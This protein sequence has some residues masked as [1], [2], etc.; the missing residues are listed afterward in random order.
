VGD[1]ETAPGTDLAAAVQTLG[2][3]EAV[4]VHVDQF[5][6][7]LRLGI[8][9]AVEVNRGDI[10]DPPEALWPEESYGDD[11]GTAAGGK[12]NPMTRTPVHDKSVLALTLQS[13]EA[14][15]AGPG[16]TLGMAAR[17]T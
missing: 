9:S 11:R 10:A 13:Y 12:E 17:L 1:T 6:D 4:T 5:K 14:F 15:K 16:P 7:L 2:L 8:M 3:D